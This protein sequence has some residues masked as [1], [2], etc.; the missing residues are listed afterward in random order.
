MKRHYCRPDSEAEPG[1][2]LC[3]LIEQLAH[4]D[5]LEV[6]DICHLALSFRAL[7]LILSA[8]EAKG[9]RL[10]VL[11][12]SGSPAESMIDRFR[13]DLRRAA[14]VRAAARGAYAGNKGSAPN[15]R[16]RGNREASQRRFGA[17]PHCDAVGVWS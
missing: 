5:V 6:P 16:H 8:L 1:P 2:V 9:A 12:V 10:H 3:S 11:H 4:G 7:K 14:V 15:G 17:T 13:R